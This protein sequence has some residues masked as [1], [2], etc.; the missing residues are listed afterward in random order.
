MTNSPRP[1]LAIAACVLAA[2]LSACGSDEPEK[3]SDSMYCDL[4]NPAT[5]ADV[6][7]DDRVKASGGP[8]PKTET[9]RVECHIAPAAGGLITVQGWDLGTPDFR[10][11]KEAEFNKQVADVPAEKQWS[12]DDGKGFVYF[13][14]SKTESLPFF[15][16]FTGAVYITE[17]RSINVLLKTAPDQADAF[18]EIAKAVAEEFDANLD[19]WD[20][21]HP[22]K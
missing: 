5:V 10:A 8:V 7:A 20:A 19:A 3:E 4:I 14:D 17:D 21:E 16:P 22:T 13:D 15:S 11:L 12:T 9:R 2:S 18:A 6:V 1:L